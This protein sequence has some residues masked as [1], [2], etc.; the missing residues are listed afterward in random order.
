MWLA[1]ER[2]RERGRWR[3]VLFFHFFLFLVFFFFWGVVL[4]ELSINLAHALLVIEQFFFDGELFSSLETSG[5]KSN[6]NHLLLS[7]STIA[8]STRMR[9]V[10]N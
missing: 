10:M 2:G 1:E 9:F 8:M 7:S 6:N 4:W 3:Y 5:S